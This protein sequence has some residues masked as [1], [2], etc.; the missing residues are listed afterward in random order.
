MSDEALEGNLI[1]ISTHVFNATINWTIMAVGEGN[2]LSVTIK[3]PSDEWGG[4]HQ[5]VDKEEIKFAV[6]AHEKIYATKVKLEIEENRGK[7]K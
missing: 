3:F 6:T 4:N 2:E 1:L 5:P 7:S